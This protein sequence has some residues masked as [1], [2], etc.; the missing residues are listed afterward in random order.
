MS[1]VLRKWFHRTTI[2]VLWVCTHK[3]IQCIWRDGLWKEENLCQLYIK[4]QIRIYKEL[5]G[6]NT[7]KINHLINEWANE[8]N[9]QFQKRK[10]KR[11]INFFLKFSASLAVREW[12]I[13]AILRF[14]FPHVRMASDMETKTSENMGKDK[15]A[16]TVAGK[17]NQ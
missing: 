10:Y 8:L 4:Q 16:C 13:K 2:S 6:L 12:Q 17:V 5:H 3:K 9:G 14:H 15:C 1:S 11:P 7:I